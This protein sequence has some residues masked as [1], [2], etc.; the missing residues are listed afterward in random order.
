LAQRPALSAEL[1]SKMLRLSDLGARAA[2]PTS[3]PR[4][5][6]LSDAALNPGSV[7]HGEATVNFQIDRVDIGR[8]FLQRLAGKLMISHGTLSVTPISAD[9]LHGKL[10]G[11]VRMD[12]SSDDPADEI[13]LQFTGIQLGELDHNAKGPS[14]F[15]AAMNAQLNL[16]GRGSSLHRLAAS[17][18]G[19]ITSSVPSG[20]LRESLAELSGMD[21]RGLGLLL[22]KSQHQT[23]VRCAVANFEA[24][25]GTLIS[26]NIIIDTDDVLISADGS[27]A[28]DT[29][30]VR[31][32]LR[33]HPKGVRLLRL[34]APLL[35]SGTLLHPTLAIERPRSMQLIDRG[36]TQNADCAALLAH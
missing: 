20:M 27:I 2:N 35:L 14:R 29:E 21:W 10:N 22:S 3:A 32:A 1:H 16:T 34:S 15:E 8:V 17:A 18:N 7:R 31:I 24:H 4:A 19:S 30:S 6:L 12:A 33:G 28:L 5:L 36:R 11:R 23:A 13:V 25:D 26:S 9:L